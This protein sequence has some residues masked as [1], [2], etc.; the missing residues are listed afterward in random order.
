MVRLVCAVWEVTARAGTVLA[1]RAVTAV[2]APKGR[3][4]LETSG[5]VISQVIDWLC[6]CV[7][8]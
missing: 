8:S 3:N 4:R 6:Q 7:W 1:R 5:S 2:Q